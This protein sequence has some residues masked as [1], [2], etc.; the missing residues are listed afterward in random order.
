MVRTRV[1]GVKR[2]QDG[3]K[4]LHVTR[5]CSSENVKK[6]STCRNMGETV[7]NDHHLT[8]QKIAK[9]L[10]VNREILDLAGMRRLCQNIAPKFCSKHKMKS[11][12]IFLGL[13]TILLQEF[14][15]VWEK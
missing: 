13:S 15:F 4:I 6:Q 10:H 8:V 7:R 1:F 14:Y 11:K 5:H 3:I 12:Y 9:E 2:F